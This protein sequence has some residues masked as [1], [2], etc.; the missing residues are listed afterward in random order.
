MVHMHSDGMQQDGAG[1]WLPWPPSRRERDTVYVV[2]TPEDWAGRA[3]GLGEHGM[4]AGDHP[5]PQ[6]ASSRE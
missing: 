3:S 6:Q 2:P 4:P 1:T 5:D